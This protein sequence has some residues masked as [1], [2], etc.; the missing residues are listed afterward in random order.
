MTAHHDPSASTRRRTYL[1][2]PPLAV[3]TG[4][5]AAT[6]ATRDIRA[7]DVLSGMRDRCSEWRM[8]N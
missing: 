1:A 8:E 3:C 7:V 4:P 5:H 2:N 6:S